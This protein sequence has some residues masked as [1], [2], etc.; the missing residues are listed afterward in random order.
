MVPVTSGTKVGDATAI[1]GDVKSGDKAIA[2]PPPSLQDGALA[3]IES[4]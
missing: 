1:T 2:K 4:K 3:K